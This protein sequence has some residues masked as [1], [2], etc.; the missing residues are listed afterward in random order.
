M[1]AV[2]NQP[3]KAGDPLVVLED[4]DYRDALALAEAQLAAQQAAVE[5]IDSQAGGGA[6]PASPRPRRGSRRRRRR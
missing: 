5:R 4:G 1:P 6:T 2:E 3:V